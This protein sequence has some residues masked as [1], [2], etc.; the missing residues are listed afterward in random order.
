MLNIR[1]IIDKYRRDYKMGGSL[2]NNDENRSQCQT[3]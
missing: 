3:H 1:H 2:E